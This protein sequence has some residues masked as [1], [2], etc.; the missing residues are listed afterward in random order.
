MENGLTDCFNRNSVDQPFKL[1]KKLL[2]LPDI[3]IAER[4]ICIIHSQNEGVSCFS[5]KDFVLNLLM[6]ILL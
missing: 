6:S 2:L 3:D 5:A 1:G 4:E